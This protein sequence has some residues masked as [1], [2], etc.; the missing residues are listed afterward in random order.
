MTLLGLFSPE[1]P[2]YFLLV[3]ADLLKISFFI[4]F[5]ETYLQKPHCVVIEN[6]SSNKT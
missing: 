4:F 5:D 2:Y 6:I 3:N 1:S